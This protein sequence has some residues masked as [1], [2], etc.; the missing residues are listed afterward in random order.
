MKESELTT[1]PICK[2]PLE[3]DGDGWIHCPKCKTHST[4]APKKL[5]W[6]KLCEQEKTNVILLRDLRDR[7]VVIVV[8]GV[9]VFLL[10][11]CVLI[12]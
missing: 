10:L 9:M 12:S 11:L 7:G 5:I 6:K 1:C 2:V 8:L 4:N 3:M